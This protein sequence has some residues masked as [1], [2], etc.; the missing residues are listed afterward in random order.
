MELTEFERNVIL[1][2]RSFPHDSST[3]YRHAIVIDVRQKSKV[4]VFPVMNPETGHM[5]FD[6]AKAFK[7]DDMLEQWNDTL[8]SLMDNGMRLIAELNQEDDVDH[9]DCTLVQCRLGLIQE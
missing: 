1:Q 8:G 2:L 7:N 4:D 9:P 3:P 5:T 6:V